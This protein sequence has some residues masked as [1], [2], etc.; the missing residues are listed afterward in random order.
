VTIFITG[1]IGFIA[2]YLAMAL[3]EDE[4]Q[5]VALLRLRHSKAVQRPLPAQP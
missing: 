5:R 2:S 4:G 3:L 1:G